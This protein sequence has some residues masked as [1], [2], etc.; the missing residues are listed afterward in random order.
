MNEWPTVRNILMVIFSLFGVILITDPTMI[1]LGTSDS[2]SQD[3]PKIALV[4]VLFP[5]LGSVLFSAVLSKYSKIQ[6]QA[7]YPYTLLRK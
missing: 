4:T 7:I 5:A 1:G 2:V 3:Y 6:N